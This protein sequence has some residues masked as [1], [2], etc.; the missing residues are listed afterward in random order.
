MSRFVV[1]IALLAT[2]F[3][4]W[5]QT[6]ATLTGKITSESEV[7]PG[8]TVH[9]LN[10]NLGTASNSDGTF[11]L[12]NITPG[13]YRVQISAVGFAS[14]EQSISIE[15]NATLNVELKESTT[16]LDA[17]VVTAQKTEEELQK[18][19]VSIS[20]ISSRQVQQYRL[21]N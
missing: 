1:V 13:T 6:G 19:P 18:I 20:S 2:S 4:T 12:K 9:I 17:V 15:A 3:C 21:W 5:A 16:Q 11:E 7:V 8:A 14:I 10:T